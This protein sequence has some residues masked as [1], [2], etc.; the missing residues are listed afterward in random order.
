MLRRRARISGYDLARVGGVSAARGRLNF[1]R[2]CARSPPTKAE[3]TSLTLRERRGSERATA[4][5]RQDKDS[6][7]NGGVRETERGWRNG[8]ERTHVAALR[9]CTTRQ[10]IPRSRR[11]TS[12]NCGRGARKYRREYRRY[13]FPERRLSITLFQARRRIAGAY[14]LRQAQGSRQSSRV[15]TRPRVSQTPSAVYR[16]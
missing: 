1:A 13:R 16:N 15:Y 10:I 7:R 11:K 4:R 14:T 6:E 3:I 12:V 5:T 9:R 2:T 8:D